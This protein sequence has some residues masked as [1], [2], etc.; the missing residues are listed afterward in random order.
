MRL[1]R[2]VKRKR[3]RESFLVLG[4]EW[5]EFCWRSG[6]TTGRKEKAGR[7]RANSL[8]Y[9]PPKKKKNWDKIRL[10]G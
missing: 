7:M 10:K 1:N 9:P 3:E 2:K 5:L 8:H 6:G 4:N